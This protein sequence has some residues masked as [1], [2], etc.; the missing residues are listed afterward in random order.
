VYLR[1]RR[2]TPGG[3]RAHRM[4]RDGQRQPAVGAAQVRGSSPSR[5]GQV[6]RACRGFPAG[7]NKH[8]PLK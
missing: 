8:M 4:Q 3:C 1:A 5:S 7:E 2:G 6:H